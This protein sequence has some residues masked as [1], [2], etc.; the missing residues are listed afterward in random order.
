[1]RSTNEARH[2]LRSINDDD[3]LWLVELHNDPAVLWNTRDP[4]PIT[5]ESHM[6]WWERVRLDPNEE[7][8]IFAVDGTRAGLVKIYSIDRQNR[9]CVLGADLHP[10]FRGRRL[11]VP[12]WTLLLD[13][14]FFDLRMH[15]VGL[16]TMEHNVVARHVYERLGFVEEGR[17]MHCHLREGM[18]HDAVCMYMLEDSWR[19]RRMA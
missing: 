13:R 19:A 16:S 4:R 7:R 3:H 14:C 12:M 10:T 5:L 15:R 2:V 11:A 8:W 1:M 9:H 6:R 18:F 17:I